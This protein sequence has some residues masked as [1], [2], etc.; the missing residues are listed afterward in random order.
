MCARSQQYS[1]TTH[2]LL[3]AYGSKW[4]ER[5]L[6]MFTIYIDDSGSAPEH[7]M[8]I[9]SG[10]VIPALQIPRLESEWDTFRSK[11]GI[12]DFHASE[13]LARNPHSDFANWSDERVRRVFNRIV[14][15]TLKYSVKGFCIAIRK[16]DYE[17]VVTPEMKAAIGESYFSWAMS[18]VLGLAHDWAEERKVPMEYV[19]DRA[20]KK[21]ER[22]VADALAFADQAFP[23]HFLGHYSFRSR[24]DVPALQMADLFAWTCFQKA[25]QARFNHPMN[26][27]ADEIS[28]AYE[29]AHGGLWRVVQSLNRE[30]IEMWVAQN[31]DNPRT[32][33]IIDFKKKR[34][35]ARKP[36]PKKTKSPV[37]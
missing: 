10:I 20:E 32:Q 24:K 13:C 14:Q 9:A 25:R 8:A 19:Y 34:K 11:E 18:S 5:Y 22:E 16:D 36:K 1:R 12:T 31:R 7:K 2:F 29:L 37:A 6:A 4:I 23:G 28:R 30:G 3:S 21:V 17:S 33:E 27:I 26:P 15:M 35:E